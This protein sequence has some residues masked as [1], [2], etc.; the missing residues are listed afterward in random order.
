MVKTLLK[1]ALA[2][3]L[4]LLFTACAGTKMDYASM[5]NTEMKPGPNIH[6]P[7]KCLPKNSVGSRLSGGLVLSK[8]KRIRVDDVENDAP[9]DTVNVD[10]HFHTA[11]LPVYGAIDKFRKGDMFTM[12]VGFGIADGIYAQSG[13]GINAKYMELGVFSFQRFTY[14]NFKYVGYEVDGKKTNDMI[15][16]ADQL[17]AQLGAGAY[18]S[19]FLGPVTLGYNG[20]IYRPQASLWIKKKRP[21]FNLDMPYLFTNNFSV[22]FW[23]TK[24]VEVYVNTTNLLLDFNGG[25]WSFA[26]GV[27]LWSF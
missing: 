10:A 25:N 18:G 26:A 14:Q 21:D 20:N 16:N 19:L 6:G 9:W 13:F 27:S 15:D 23:A 5:V 3:S 1:T 12:H 7:S 4:S 11:Y 2:L 17:V 24:D 8:E 22:S